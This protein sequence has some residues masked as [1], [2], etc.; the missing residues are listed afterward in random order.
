MFELINKAHGSSP[1]QQSEW[2]Q[3]GGAY[4][5]KNAS[6]EAGVRMWDKI[7]GWRQ[8]LQHMH[9][10]F[11]PNKNHAMYHYA[12]LKYYTDQEFAYPSLLLKVITSHVQ[13]PKVLC[14][15]E[16][17]LLCCLENL[18][19]PQDKLPIP[20]SKMEQFLHVQNS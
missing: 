12:S 19:I 16:S 3:L 14:P 2:E 11:D 9:R 4:A 10:I 6:L 8:N 15:A 13:G 5:G 1:I 17:I 18:P 7:C 20:Q